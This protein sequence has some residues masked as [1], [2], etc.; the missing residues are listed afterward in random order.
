MRTQKRAQ[1]TRDFT[2]LRQRFLKAC[3][4][5][6]SQLKTDYKDK[7]YHMTQAFAQVQILCMPDFSCI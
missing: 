2:H 6:Q 5:K 3:D 1:T 7:D 4:D